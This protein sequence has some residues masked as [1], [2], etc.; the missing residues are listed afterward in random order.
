MKIAQAGTGLVLLGLSL[1]LDV[2]AQNVGIGFSSPQSKLT[3][4]GNLAL[5]ADYNIAAPANGALIE[6]NTG[7]GITA[8]QV[9]LHVDGEVFVA[10]GGVTGLFWNG[11]ANIDGF[12]IDPGG[13]MGAQRGGGAGVIVSKPATYTNTWLEQFVFN[14]TAIGIIT[15]NA[16]S[17]PTGVVYG[18]T[19]DLRLKENV[20]P[21]A[22][23][24]SNLMRIQVSDYN[25]KSKP[26]TNE[27]GFI[28]QQL[29]TVLP[30]AVSPGGAN[31][32]VEPWTVDYG[33]VPPLLTKAIQDQQ[34]E[35]DALKAQTK[36]QD[37][38]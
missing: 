23:G 34:A 31:P 18:T 26:G 30:D 21:T 36:N 27:T 8:P 1:A 35:I 32:T 6:G 9:P 38:G 37:T 22:K 2:H 16:N 20:R 15:V 25:F 3:V 33:R 5:G 17:N 24:L 10:A 29:Y 19:S 28:A 13:Y 14:G 7:I 12:Q 4:N 11:T